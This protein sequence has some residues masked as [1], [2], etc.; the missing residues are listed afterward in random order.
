MRNLPAFV[1]LTIA[2]AGQRPLFAETVKPSPYWRNTVD[3]PTDAFRNQGYN[4]DDLGWIKFTIF[5]SDQTKVYFQNSKQYVFHYDWAVASV[6]EYAGMTPAQFDQ[7]T[8]HAAGQQAILGAIIMPHWTQNTPEA[9][10]V[11]E[12][13]IQFVR[14]DAYDAVQLVSLFN[15]VRSKINA[16]AG[17]Q[18][19]Y[20]PSYEQ[21][22]S[23]EQNRAYLE[24]EGV[25]VSS[26]SRWARGNACYSR[27][28]A[29][30][31]LTFVNGSQIAS[32]YRTGTL[33]PGDILLTDGV[34][35]EVPP[36]AGIISLS[37]ST[38]NSHV[39]IL[40]NTL[41]SPFVHLA[42][43]AD[44]AYAQQL[45]NQRIVLR[46]YGPA[47]AGQVDLL[48]VEGVLTED[49]I[50]E[51]LALKTA[52]PLD[53]QPIT[54]YKAYSAPTDN[55]T[56]SDIRYFGGKAS[57]YGL[58]R[59]TIP[60][61]APVAGAIS[62][63]LWTA[64]LDQTLSGGQ[65]LR[66]Y[67]HG[68]LGG[69]TWPPNMSTLAGDLDNI[70]S[71]IRSQT[72]TSFN[73]EQTQAIIAMLS[74]PQYGFDPNRNIRFRSSTNVEDTDQFTGAGLYDSYSGCL[75]DDL[76]GDSIGPSICDSTEQNERGV[77]RAIRRVF[78]SFYNDNAFLERLRHGVNENQVGMAMLVHHS[79]PDSIEL[80]N[81]VAT[82]NRTLYSRSILMVTQKG[83]V[84]VT[85]PVDGSI[86]E[87]VQADVYGFGTYLTILGY[88]N[89][90]PLGG[91]V[92]AWEADYRGLAAM[93]V[94]VGNAYGTM[95]GKPTYALD[96][97]YKKVAPTGAI[98]VKQVRE[99]PQP[100]NQPSITPFLLDD[101]TLY[102]T[103]QGEYGDVF[104][105][106]RL[107]GRL[108]IQTQNLWLT[109]ENL[110]QS[111]YANVTFEFLDDGRI[112]S[113]TGVPSEWPAAAHACT[114]G[115]A[116]DSWS[117]SDMKNP[118]R[119][120][121]R[122]TNIP[123]KVSPSQ[124]PIL[125]IRDMGYGCLELSAE[126]D[127]PEPTV[128]WEGPGTTR[129]EIARMCQC[130]GDEGLGA[131]Q[132][133]IMTGSKGETITARFY[134]PP[135]PTGIGAG[136]TAPLVRWVETIITGYTT[137]PITLRGEYAQTYRPEHHNF[138]EQ[139]LFE[140]RLDPDVPTALL[141]QLRAK[142][143][144]MIHV[145]HDRFGP[146]AFTTYG[147]IPPGD[148]DRDNDVDQDDFGH[149]QSCLTGPALG[150]AAGGCH[151]AD[152]DND[153]DVDLEDFGIFQR[154]LS[155][156]R[157]PAQPTCGD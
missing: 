23:A 30:G 136:Y 72:L 94:S 16:I 25:F 99:I 126:Y 98:E 135:E 34:P 38:P 13:G 8:L 17:T 59:R 22:A 88:S 15:L 11:R 2:T 134:W 89:L 120:T 55:L 46:A 110:Q 33:Q 74:D 81:G 26:V 111:F 12:Y 70:R 51:I 40:A 27:G 128:T 138:G 69:Y 127:K 28:W 58:L 84:S 6:Q 93:L 113:N 86:P 112:R 63:D 90:V 50:S 107:K 82:L 122:T 52:T 100:D 62:F 96:F 141:A 32:A 76:D 71:T 131:L 37:P 103:F 79:Y 91:K 44:A 60:T 66:Q 64:F 121:L 125:T 129:N 18:P 42:I 77:F 152:L 83:A 24:S 101:P 20:F 5:V 130:V 36:L 43:A 142:N 7:I 54:T 156:P 154:C 148:F 10:L 139:F 115:T 145:S 123:D 1:L 57:N 4:L 68:R 116:T 9:E 53:I 114:S 3:F 151:D 78:A 150:P 48:Q 47:K 104:A 146:S 65:T 132:E 61:A 45:V 92:M 39:A 118:R 144:R 137:S 157:V 80:A 14:Q 87:Q 143:I 29:L 124:S 35:A 97:E 109:A 102:C 75:A 147:Y 49:Q 108:A 140:P 85:N 19:F 155:G 41:S 95:T 21:Q 119:Y 117:Q 153:Q 73:A 105:N 106:H 133:R 67:I 56:P 31:R 149:F